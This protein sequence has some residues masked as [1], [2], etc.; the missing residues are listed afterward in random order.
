MLRTSI[1]STLLRPCN[2]SLGML[3]NPAFPIAISLAKEEISKLECILSK[4]PDNSQQ[5][6]LYYD[7]DRTLEAARYREIQ[8][9]I[10][11]LEVAAEE[12]ANKEGKMKGGKSKS[13]HSPNTEKTAQRSKDQGPAQSQP[14]ILIT[15][16]RLAGRTLKVRSSCP[17]TLSWSE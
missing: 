6:K 1:A 10:T 9:L 12:N 17:A 15:T 14:R 3:Y 8:E 13:S 4:E 16:K 5:F 2:A 11:R 7:I